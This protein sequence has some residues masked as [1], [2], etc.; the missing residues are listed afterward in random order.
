MQGRDCTTRTYYKMINEE[1]QTIEF[2][3]KDGVYCIEDDRI[4]ALI[5]GYSNKL[6]LKYELLK[7]SAWL[8]KNRSRQREKKLVFRF[9]ICW[10]MR[11]LKYQKHEHKH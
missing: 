2:E 9:L 6:D 11:S 3:A 1:L 10:L 5:E 8:R 4:Q 7:A